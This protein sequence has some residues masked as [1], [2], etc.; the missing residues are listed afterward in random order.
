[1]Q[2][3][4]KHHRKPRSLGGQNT[5]E[6]ISNVD[7][8]QHRAWHTL[9]INWTPYKICK[10]INQKWLDPEYKFVVIKTE[11][12]TDNELVA[13]LKSVLQNI[14]P[15]KLACILNEQ[16]LPKDVMF[17]VEHLPEPHK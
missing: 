15:I 10:R 17:T 4:S 6:N 12:A 14:S 16:V 3:T 1:M 13:E 5:P 7:E 9:F 11:D 8:V 2:H